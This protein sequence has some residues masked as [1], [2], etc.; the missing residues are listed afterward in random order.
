MS[1]PYIGEIKLV[2][3]NFAPMDWLPCDGRL[4]QISEAQYQVLFSV[5]GTTYGG[6]GATTFA[7][8]NLNGRGIIGSGT[9]Y[10]CGATDGAVATTLTMQTMP[11]H[12]HEAQFS[13][14]TAPTV[15][16]SIAVNTVAGTQASPANAFLAP[17]VQG[18]AAIQSY[19]SAPTAPDPL[20]GVAVSAPG[21]TPC[22]ADPDMLGGVTAGGAVGGVVTVS[23]AGAP[24]SIPMPTLPPALYCNYIICCV[25]IYPAR[26]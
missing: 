9:L 25:G 22:G 1:E 14:T 8:P 21:S 11:A 23:G 19:A 17:T 18:A 2:G 10:P 24:A 4:L 5:I 7:L 13:M 26:P 16:A 20:G 15:Q 12:T 6:D 3:F